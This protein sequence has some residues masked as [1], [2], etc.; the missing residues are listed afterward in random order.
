MAHPAPETLLV[1]FDTY[2]PAADL[3]ARLPSAMDARA[4]ALLGGEARTGGG[5][6]GRDGSDAGARRVAAAALAGFPASGNDGGCHDSGSAPTAAAAPAV[7]PLY[8]VRRR[9][10]AAAGLPTDFVTV[11]AVAGRGAAVVALLAA[12][13]SVRRVVAEQTHYRSLASVAAVDAVVA[14]TGATAEAAATL[15]ASAE[16]A[17][18]GGVASHHDRRLGSMA[19]PSL[20]GFGRGV[21]PASAVNSS[22]DNGDD[23]GRRS[24]GPRPAPVRDVFGASAIWRQGF[25]GSGVRV[26]VF[27]TGISAGNPHF[28]NIVERTDWTAE[29]SYDDSVGHGTFVAGLIAGSHPDCP[30]LA[31][32]ADLITFR[33]FTGAQVSYTSWFLDAF[34]YALHTQV[35]VLNL[36][37]GGPDFA[38][39]PFTE[40]VNEVTAAGVIVVSAIGNDGP[41]WGSLNNPADMMEV[42]GVG[43]VE[44]D[45]RI[46]PFSSRGMTTHELARPYESYGRVKPD[47]VTYG[48]QVQAPNHAN[49]GSCKRLSGTSVASPVV[50]GAL[51]LVASI[52]PAERRRAVVTPASVKRVLIESAARLP[53]SSIYEQGAGLL[54]IAA[55]AD[56]MRQVDREWLATRDALTAR[57]SAAAAAAAV[58]ETFPPMP[59]EAGGAHPTEAQSD[60]VMDDGRGGGGADFATEEAVPA[61]GTDV[62]LPDGSTATDAVHGETDDT[63]AS[64]RRRLAL[65]AATWPSGLKGRGASPLSPRRQRPRR[66]DAPIVFLPPRRAAVGTVN[67]RARRLLDALGHRAARVSLR[68]PLPSAARPAA[69]ATHGHTAGSVRRLRPALL[70]HAPRSPRTTMNAALAAVQLFPAPATAAVWGLPPPPSTAGVSAMAARGHPRGSARTLLDGDNGSGDGGDDDPDADGGLGWSEGAPAMAAATPLLPP[71]PPLP[72]LEPVAAPRAALLPNY[73][74]LTASGCPYMWPH[75]AQP[76]FPGSAPTV[77]NVTVLNLGGV[78]GAITSIAWAPGPGGELLAVA[79]SLPDRFWPWAAGL[80]VHIQVAD[81]GS[82]AAAA[83]ALG[84]L[85]ATPTVASG[86]LRL[87]VASVVE[88][89]ASAVELPIRADVVAAPPRERRLLWDTYH[90]L[91]YP[92]AYVPR[93]SLAETKDMLDWLGDHPH[94]NFQALYRHLRGAGYFVDIWT[95]P[96]TCLP[97]DVATHYGALLVIDAED[98]FAPGEVTSITAAVHDGGLA[99]IVV[100]EWYS[101]P[102]MRDVRFEDDNTRSWWTP[103]IGGG[104]VPA[105]NELLRPHGLALGDTVLSGEVT[106]AAPYPRYG[107]MSGAPIVRVDL[108]GEA[109]RARGLRPHLPRRRPGGGA[110]APAASAA[111][112]PLGSPVDAVVLAISRSARGAVAVLGDS[113]CVDTAYAGGNCHALFTAVV[114]HAVATAASRSATYV[115][116]LSGPDVL[117]GSAPLLGVAAGDVASPPP[118][119]GVALLR[120]HSRVLAPPGAA[121]RFRDLSNA[122]YVPPPPPAAAAVVMGTVSPASSASSSPARDSPRRRMTPYVDS[123]V[124]AVT[125]PRARRAVVLGSQAYNPLLGVP[126]PRAPW[127]EGEETGALA[128]GRRRA[129][130]PGGG[131]GVG[132]A[133][134]GWGGMGGVL[135]G[136]RN[137]AAWWA[138]AGAVAASPE[139]LLLAGVLCVAASVLVRRG[140]GCGCRCGR[141]QRHWGWRRRGVRPCWRW[142]WRGGWNCGWLFAPLRWSR[143]RGGGHRPPLGGQPS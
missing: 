8:T 83:T 117:T 113:N 41:L 57:A 55:A 11:M 97:A 111:A 109:L 139:V 86:V 134:M 17:A 5:S 53:G 2:A 131:L 71:P 70:P 98:Y 132:G 96:A 61:G 40:K 43:G 37:I 80:G 26:A 103:V 99:L 15:A 46:A 77:V 124:E 100:A 127:G 23:G 21:G 30:G 1:L 32:A 63:D 82:S 118:P 88:G 119:S 54:D 22:A 44:P 49:H 14:A 114:G 35:H 112:P 38:D 60:G 105:L 68:R 116:L 6:T 66:A 27:D 28:G 16:V 93:D 125:I 42:I 33:V 104:N 120:P 58:S 107:F 29:H 69:G 135:G 59:A 74:D 142:G 76:L 56:V 136:A 94:T 24:Y 10:N 128:G 31:P 3:E 126:L 51:A 106:G 45:G 19:G 81:R 133:G 75:C 138:T 36:S 91:R 141:G 110:A 9:F 129:A 18:G 95:Q 85:A 90:S 122:C 39:E 102:L 130:S 50:A 87:T 67:G 143:G 92:P 12:V 34:N 137:G 115:P 72:P 20:L 121:G 123:V 52:V 4:W 108:G 101:R 89:T 64:L 84:N 79:A 73:L 140:G 65:R 48:R 47:V 25:F 13:P 78:K 62:P 7:P